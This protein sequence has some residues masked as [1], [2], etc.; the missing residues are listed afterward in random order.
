MATYTLTSGQFAAHEK[1]LV[2][3]TVDTVTIPG[4]WAY[5]TVVAID[6][7]DEIYFTI[8][9]STPTAQGASSFVIPATVAVSKERVLSH[10]D[11]T[12]VVKLISDGT[13]KYSVIAGVDSR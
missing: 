3:A 8:D 6:G 11:N 1:T 2:A 9:G 4:R 7:L 5:V 12:T 10:V 13:P